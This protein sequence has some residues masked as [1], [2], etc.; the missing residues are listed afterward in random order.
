MLDGMLGGLGLLLAM[1]PKVAWLE[2]EIGSIWKCQRNPDMKT[3]GEGGHIQW[4]KAD[5]DVEE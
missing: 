4:H 1:D 3:G 2:L 5:V